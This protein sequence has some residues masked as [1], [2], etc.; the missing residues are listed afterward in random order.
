M[1][2]SSGQ[3][4]AA[5]ARAAVT[6]TRNSARRCTSTRAS[7]R[8]CSRGTSTTLATRPPITS[9]STSDL[10]SGASRSLARPRVH[11][12]RKRA[13]GARCS[14]Q[15][16]ARDCAARHRA[17]RGAIPRLWRHVLGGV[18]AGADPA[19][20]LRRAGAASGA[21][22][23]RARRELALRQLPCAGAPLRVT[24]IRPPLLRS[25]QTTM[26]LSS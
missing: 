6:A 18:E 9:R 3:R 10:P 25:C 7:T 12:A 22:R 24:G 1:R 8:A 2:R 14:A 15:A 21:L 20:R 4:A 17:R 13:C 11:E 5:S 26:D 19:T 16:C 23:T